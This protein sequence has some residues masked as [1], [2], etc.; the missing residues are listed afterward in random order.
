MSTDFLTRSLELAPELV[1]LRRYFHQHPE[2]GTS[3]PQTEA[4]VHRQLT[5]MGYQPQ[6]IPNAGLLI[7]AGQGHGRTLLIRGEMDALPMEE[8]SGETFSSHCPGA[9]HTCGHDLHTT[10]LLGAAKLLK[11]QEAQLPGTV[12]LFF[13][14]G[15]ETLEGAE[16]AIRSGVL[17]HP[18]VD[19]ALGVHVQPL[20]PVGCLNIPKGAFL[21]STDMFRIH[22]HGKGC[23]G[24]MPHLGVDPIQIAAHIIL[25]LHTLQVKEVPADEPVVLNIC[26]MEAG[27]ASNI[28]PNEACLLGTLRTYNDSI[29]QTLKERIQDISHGVAQSF[30]GQAQVEFM[31][32]CPTTVNDPAFVDFI[33]R[34]LQTFGRTFVSDPDYRLQVSDDFAFYSQTVPSAMIMLGCQPDGGERIPNHSPNVRYNETVLPIGAALLA[35]LAAG[36]Q[37][38]R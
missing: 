31:E 4:Y 28:V 23:H 16:N 14:T 29:C 27:S 10:F 17:L 3:L 24:A 25:A 35:H 26:K 9:A 18:N 12:K 20:L 32:H 36:W 22:I 5:D 11:E 7:S 33:D 21:S 37:A 19:A 6:H 38:R 8:T 2:T 30:R 15:E 1:R 13:Q 34:S